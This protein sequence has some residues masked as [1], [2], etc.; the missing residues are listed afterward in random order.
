QMAQRPGNEIIF[1]FHIGIV[2]LSAAEHPGDVAADGRLFSN[3]KMFHVNFSVSCLVGL[4]CLRI[5]PCSAL[6]AQ[7]SDTLWNPVPMSSLVLEMRM[8]ACGSFCRI[9]F[10]SRTACTRFRAVKMMYLSLPE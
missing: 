8:N 6:L 10:R 2:L 5:V 7:A 1:P 3:N 4:R 9:K